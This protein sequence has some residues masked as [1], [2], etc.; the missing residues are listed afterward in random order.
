MLLNNQKYLV[1][2]YEFSSD[3]SD[4]LASI[5]SFIYKLIHTYNDANLNEDLLDIVVPTDVDKFLYYEEHDNRSTKDIQ[6][7]Q[8][9]DA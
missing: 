2:H 4:Y 8:Q 5:T 9:H 7:M 6:K 3:F 1:V